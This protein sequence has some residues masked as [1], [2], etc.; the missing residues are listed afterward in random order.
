MSQA[1]GGPRWVH[2]LVPSALAFVALRER[3]LGVCQSGLGI[4]GGGTGDT[5]E[6][7]AGQF[8][9]VH[10]PLTPDAAT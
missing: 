3:S 5:P 4:P 10:L 6:A 1:S 8:L 7:T 9:H 2:H